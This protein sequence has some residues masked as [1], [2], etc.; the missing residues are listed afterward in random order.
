MSRYTP[1]TSDEV[2][3]SVGSKVA[4]NERGEYAVGEVIKQPLK[5]PLKSKITKK[6]KAKNGKGNSG[7]ST[8]EV[9][10]WRRSSRTESE[11]SDQIPDS[12]TRSSDFKPL[13]ESKQPRYEQSEPVYITDTVSED[14]K[15]PTNDVNGSTPPGMTGSPRPWFKQYSV[16]VKGGVLSKRN[17]SPKLP[18]PEKA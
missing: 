12:R 9:L 14:V 6:Q 8:D 4:L 11:S 3:S 17:L 10:S 7:V 13:S 15:T 1:Q 5:L 16:A 2:S 18:T